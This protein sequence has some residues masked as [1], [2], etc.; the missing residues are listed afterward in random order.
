VDG[1]SEERASPRDRQRLEI[2]SDTLDARGVHKRVTVELSHSEGIPHHTAQFDMGIF[3][4][5]L[6]FILLAAVSLNYLWKR[7]KK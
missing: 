6:A 7:R 2:R 3:I 4:V 1:T 5:S